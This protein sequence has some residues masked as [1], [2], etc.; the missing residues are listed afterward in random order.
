VERAC[1]LR[2]DINRGFQ[3]RRISSASPVC[4]YHSLQPSV[5]YQRSL[6]SSASTTFAGYPP[7]LNYPRRLVRSLTRIR[8]LTP[9]TTSPRRLPPPTTDPS[10]TTLVTST[11]LADY[12]PLLADCPCQLPSPTNIAN[13]SALLDLTT[14]RYASSSNS[15]SAMSIHT[16]GEIASP[17]WKLPL[18]NVIPIYTWANMGS[19]SSTAATSVEKLPSSAKI[20]VRAS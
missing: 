20:E 7:R 14:V 11:T 8:S 17:Q 3:L 18:Q 9:T 16:F 19:E 5:D 12:P 15:S 13:D 4:T 2:D 6:R 10:P 1:V